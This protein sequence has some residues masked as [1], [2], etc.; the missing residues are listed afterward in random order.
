MMFCMICIRSASKKNI[1]VDKNGW[2]K[3]TLELDFVHQSESSKVLFD[4]LK[5]SII[6]LIVI[7]SKI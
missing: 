2:K 7:F 4:L 3:V 5:K 1:F 6:V